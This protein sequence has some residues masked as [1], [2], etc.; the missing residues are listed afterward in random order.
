MGAIL[1]SPFGQT[2]LGIAP[3]SIGSAPG[4]QLVLNDAGVEAHHAEIR[5]S[6]NDYSI[7]DLGSGSGTFV[8][9]Q[10]LYANVPQTLQN[11]D[12][13]RIG[14]VQLTY[15]V[16]SSASI[17]PT[18]YASPGSST[19]AGYPAT[20]LSPGGSPP[21]PSTYTPPPVPSVSNPYAATPS[22][23][24]A[25]PPPPFATSSTG[26]TPSF[27]PYAPPPRKGMGKGLRIALGI[28]G[29]VVVLFIVIFVIAAMSGPSTTPTQAFQALCTAYKT[30]NGQAIFNS[31][32]DNARK[33]IG[34][35]SA[36]D[37][38]QEAS[39]ITDCTTNNVDDNAD[40]G[41][42]SLTYQNIG[43]LSLKATLV[44]Q[45]K[46]WK[47]DA[48]QTIS[49]PTRTLFNYC[50]A[51]LKG[52]Y[53][54][55]YNQFDSSIQSQQGYDTEQHFAQ[56]FGNGKPTDCTLSNVDDNAGTGVVTMNV[57]GPLALDEKLV[58]KG[59]TWKISSEQQHSTPT[60]TLNNYCSALK[61]K[62]YQTAYN[63]FSSAQQAQQTES[64][65]AASFGSTTVS[66]CSVS[67]TNDTSG[68]G[69]ISYTG[70]NGAQLTAD[71]T[72]VQ[73]NGTWK[74]KTETV[75]K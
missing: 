1:H 51:L 3:V 60:L 45:D 72:L 28:V 9:E 62:D 57:G 74:I 24:S 32:T 25:A 42:V 71:Y 37:A 13:V 10:R 29:G 21:P 30:H 34:W 58:N 33:Q 14:N 23:S 50:T 5:P 17:A 4:N 16:T 12:A 54:T 6:G 52:D 53:Q 11:G 48:Q 49:S 56:S 7:V 66:D 47:I 2:I 73:E 63:Q 69:T 39:R 59:G 67:N 31:Y 18:V 55:A 35:N 46:D 27:D 75:R 36:N 43:K 26:S 22:T 64:Q 20:V 70:S 65:F 68:T 41:T 44:S 8:N 15:E 61:Q 40:T 19:D 38:Q